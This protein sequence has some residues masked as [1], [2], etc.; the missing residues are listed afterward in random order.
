MTFPRALTRYTRLVNNVAVHLA[1]HAAIAD[2]EHVG[3][4]SGVV[5]HTPVRAF[6]AG[7]T[8]L[9]GLNFGPRSD[10]Y[11][12]IKAA[13]TCRMRLGTEQLALGAPV[14]VPA[15]EA[16]KD[17]PWLFGFAL[18]R[19]VHTAQCVRLPILDSLAHVGIAVAGRRDKGLLD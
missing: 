5:R 7:N 4:K 15:G 8:V 16:A 2:L 11:L 19:V 17:M 10:W 3:R 14:L 6:R 18:R 13:G 12:N 1:G 9:I